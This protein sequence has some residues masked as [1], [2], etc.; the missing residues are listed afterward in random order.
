M[1]KRLSK[2]SF[3]L[4]LAERVTFAAIDFT[5]NVMQMSGLQRRVNSSI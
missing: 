5:V 4:R 2:N 3:P 1:L